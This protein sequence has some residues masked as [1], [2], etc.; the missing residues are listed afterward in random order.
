MF[1][2]GPEA[3]NTCHGSFPDEPDDFV[4]VAPPEGLSG[5]IDPLTRAVGAHRPHLVYDP[6]GTAS[7][8]CRECHIVPTGF[9]DPSHIDDAAGA[10]LVFGGP[11]GI[12]TTEGGARA[13]APS[14]ETSAGTCADSYCHGNFG[15]LRS[16]SA[17]DFVYTAEK[18]EGNLASPSWT[19]TTAAACGSCHALPPTGHEPFDMDQCSACHG[20]VVDDTGAIIDRT[21][22]VNGMVNVFGDEYPMSSGSP[23]PFDTRSK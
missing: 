9:D 23:A 16:G 10:E 3:C 20:E 19:D 13:P 1:P 18:I 22:H 12:A 7:D 6:D 17:W 8:V 4:N 2:D 14:Y 15:L 11:L 5:E 21:K